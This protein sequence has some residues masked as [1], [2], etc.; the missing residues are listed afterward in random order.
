MEL[1]NRP[2]IRPNVQKTTACTQNV[3][4]LTYAEVRLVICHVKLLEPNLNSTT[5][6]EVVLHTH[7]TML[8]RAQS[9]LYFNV[10]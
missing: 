3:L 1:N 10:C 6:Q 8:L 9:I 7:C 2:L 4:V 5:L